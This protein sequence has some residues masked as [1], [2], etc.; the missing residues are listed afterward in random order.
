MP[1]PSI[2][3]PCV[4]CAAQAASYEVYKD[5]MDIV[6]EGWHGYKPTDTHQYVSPAAIYTRT[7]SL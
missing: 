2:V 3:S 1:G 7:L 4:C 5:I 6:I